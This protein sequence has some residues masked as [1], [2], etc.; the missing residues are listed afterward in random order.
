MATEADQWLQ[1]VTSL[2][3]WQRGGERAPH[4]PLLLLYA[5]GRLQRTGSPDVPFVDAKSDLTRLLVEF[6][7]PRRPN[8]GYPFHHLENDGLWSV[9]TNLGEGSPGST[10]GPLIRQEAVGSLVPD[11]ARALQEDP[12]LF[13]SVVRVLLEANFPETIHSDILDAAGID[14]ERVDL[15]G[16]LAPESAGRRRD[17]AFRPAVLLAYE[18]R[19]AVCGYDGQLL[20]ESVGIEAAHI[21]WWA[22]NG[23]DEVS[24][25]VALCSLHHKLFDRGV[26]GFSPDYTIS[27]SQHFIGRSSTADAVVLAFVGKPLLE[28]QPGQPRPD[29]NHVAWHS[30]EVF[31][32][33]ERVAA[34]G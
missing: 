2:K 6:G 24:N 33:P 15:L 22:A 7:P 26:I 23:P 18:Y 13:A 30:R 32:A 34:G 3:Q 12:R 1:R 20:R 17:P 11:F 29:P 19:C 5:L 4:K 21:R 10:I 25:S 28:P 16:S 27:I 9:R 31:R 8:P 14:V